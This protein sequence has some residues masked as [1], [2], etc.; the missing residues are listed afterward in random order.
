[1]DLKKIISFY[2]SSLSLRLYWFASICILPAADLEK[3]CD[4]PVIN[5]TARSEIA[6]ELYGKNI[7]EGEYIE[8]VFPEF[9]HNVT[10]EE[11]GAF[12]CKPMNWP[13]ISHKK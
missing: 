3:S 4:P 9:F 8:Q 11:R 12:Y 2:H 1:M 5:L 13:D 10:P 7:S 6:A